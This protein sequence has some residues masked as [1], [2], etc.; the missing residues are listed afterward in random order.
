MYK[1]SNSP[2]FPDQEST[3]ARKAAE[4]DARIAATRRI[5]ATGRVA[6]FNTLMSPQQAFDIFGIGTAVDVA[7]LQSDSLVAR[8]TGLLGTGTYSD[9][10]SQTPAESSQAYQAA[11]EVVPMSFRA[12]PCAA[13]RASGSAP[14]R[15]AMQPAA[16]QT[17]PGM[18]HMAPNIVGTPDGRMFYR[19]AP[20]TNV[21]LNGYG[22]QWG[23]AMG[24]Q[25][26]VEGGGVMGWISD[27]PLLTLAIVG[28][29]LFAC[30]GRSR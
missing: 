16:E 19:G 22:P 4:S 3:R 1:P 6:A 24:G 2:I 29:G 30:F 11:P 23:D 25:G 27:N 8:A 17:V 28:G 14:A 5:S 21:G 9:V 26:Q 12:V 18:P 15:R 7:Q 20:A 10:E 13:R